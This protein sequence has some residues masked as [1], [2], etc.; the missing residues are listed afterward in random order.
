MFAIA[1]LLT[2]ESG[3][4]L[5]NFQ[6]YNA[7]TIGIVLLWLSAFL[8][9]YT[10]YDYVKKGML[11]KIT[12]PTGGST[13]FE[14]EANQYQRIVSDDKSSLLDVG[15]SNAGG[16][17]ISKIINK[18]SDTDEVIRE[19]EYFDGILESKPKYYWDSFKQ[20]D[21][22]FI[23][24]NNLFS[25]NPAIPLSNYSGYH[26]GYSRVRE[27]FSDNSKI[28]YYFTSNDDPNYRD[29][30]HFFSNDSDPN[31]NSQYSDKSLLRG[32]LRQRVVYDSNN[33]KQKTV[34]K[35]EYDKSKHS[36]AVVRLSYFCSG[37][38]TGVSLGYGYKLFYFDN[39]LTEKETIDFLDNG[40]IKHKVS[41][42]WA[43]STTNSAI[44][45]IGD[46]FL[47]AKTSNV[48][49]SGSSVGSENVIEQYK[50]PFDFSD[51][52]SS[53]MKDIRML[54]L[55]RTDTYLNSKNLSKRNLTFLSND[56][57]I[58]SE[59][60][61]AADKGG[62]LEEKLIFHAF[63][64]KGQPTETSIPEGIHTIYIYGYS[65][66]YLIAQIQNA[67]FSE[68]ATALGVSEDALEGF[69]ETH[70][71]QI[72]GLRAQKP[73]WMITTY[74]HIPLVGMKS[75]TD[76]KGQRT[77]FEYDDFNRLKHIKDHNGDILEKYEYN[78]RNE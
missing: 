11:T 74:T 41:F 65:E 30:Y 72:N 51:A 16:V 67:T 22:D 34:Y 31:P 68:V 19:F 29:E 20:E 27:N 7:H 69:N 1:I 50:Y 76:P 62:S 39:D 10:G 44:E 53:D 61:W 45:D 49:N 48:Y 9:L 36:R 47:K 40:F 71:G 58:F 24:T 33:I 64:S 60:L 73:E 38:G 26:I 77:T 46:T 42:D 17:R 6:D 2:G 14:W 37:Y 59:K 28:D 13:K 70:I 15:L 18:F 3:N 32:Y 12:Y 52:I 35:Y 4:R 43:S 56:D 54:N 5:I 25:T 21:D 63:N 57:G 8:T 66:N 75:I 23:V 78:Y 55:V